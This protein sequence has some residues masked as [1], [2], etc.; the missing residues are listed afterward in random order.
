MPND[1]S[2]IK[3]LIFISTTIDC[4]RFQET[5]FMQILI[6]GISSGIGQGLTKYYLERGHHV[7]GI[8]RRGYGEAND[9]LKDIKLDLGKIETLEANLSDLSWPDK[10]FDLVV[11]N[12]GILG[13]LKDLSETDM[14]DLKKIMDINLWSYKVCIDFLRKQQL[15]GSQCIAI[16]SGAAVNGNR[17]WSGYSISKAALNM[18]IKLYAAECPSCHFT[19]F[20]PGLV[21]S[22]MQEHIANIPQSDK[23]PSISRIQ[24][25]RNTPNM[26]DP[27]TFAIRFDQVLKD[28]KD[29]ESGSFLDIR[30]M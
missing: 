29:Y 27:N 15:L 4:N 28:L 25:A 18:L 17:G 13:E 1:K 9:K 12:A 7:W 26:P 22:A 5:T 30:K 20:A 3:S 10:P 2:K 23:L 16:S 24:A 11:L 19:A 14:S 6:T 8:S 21:D